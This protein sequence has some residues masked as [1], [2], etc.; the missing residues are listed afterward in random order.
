[1]RLQ[2]GMTIAAPSCVLPQSQTDSPGSSLSGVLGTAAS[3]HDQQQ[4]TLQ[5]IMPEA[6]P[7]GC[8]GMRRNCAE[9]AAGAAYSQ[10]H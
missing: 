5:R 3:L 1:M 9:R 4:A 7:G 10:K 6:M 8:P 2:V